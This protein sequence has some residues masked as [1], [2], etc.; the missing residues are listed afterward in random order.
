MCHVTFT[1]PLPFS[2]LILSAVV[3]H[4]LNQLILYDGWLGWWGIRWN[5]G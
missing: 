1:R 2:S 4:C 5:V 3:L